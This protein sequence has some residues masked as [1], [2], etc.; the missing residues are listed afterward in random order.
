MCVIGIIIAELSTKC[1]QHDAPFDLFT[2]SFAATAADDL[3]HIG[4]H[5]GAMTV[6]DATEPR[7]IRRCFGGCQYVISGNKVIQIREVN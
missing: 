2:K 7:Q 6:M 3:I 5:F 1:A 4:G